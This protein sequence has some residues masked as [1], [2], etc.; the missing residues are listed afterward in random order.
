MAT[1]GQDCDYNYKWIHTIFYGVDMLLLYVRK[2]LYS[3][4]Y[5]HPDCCAGSCIKLWGCVQTVVQEKESAA[6]EASALETAW[7]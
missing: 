6:E 3:I 4:F 7:E 2:Y 5:P 1:I